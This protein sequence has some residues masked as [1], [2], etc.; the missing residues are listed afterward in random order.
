MELL[1]FSCGT[2]EIEF[3]Y[4]RSCVSDRQQ[5]R[6]KVIQQ[7]VIILHEWFIFEGY[8]VQKRSEE[9]GLR[10]VVYGAQRPEYC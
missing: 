3:A 2:Q 10:G 6:K 8:H 9:E 5:Y 1:R 7:T 4:E